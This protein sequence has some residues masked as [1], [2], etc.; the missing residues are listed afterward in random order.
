[1]TA[2]DNER[3]IVDTSGR[4]MA[5]RLWPYELARIDCWGLTF[6][7]GAIRYGDLPFE[8]R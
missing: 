8:S 6:N 2:A 7:P 1:M 5:V 4:L 3:L